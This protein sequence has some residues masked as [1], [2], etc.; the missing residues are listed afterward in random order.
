[1]VRPAHL[2]VVGKRGVDQDGPRAIDDC[3]SVA[4]TAK[5]EERAAEDMATYLRS[6]STISE[7][8]TLDGRKLV[9]EIEVRSTFVTGRDS[10]GRRVMV[11]FA[12]IAAVVDG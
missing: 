1:M 9:A 6:C 5:G 12:G 8:T 7:V 11:P 2:R 3:S 10:E 4:A